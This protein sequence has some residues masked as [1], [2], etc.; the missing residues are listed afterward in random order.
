M[1]NV[2]LPPKVSSIVKLRELFL[3]TV[4]VAPAEVA[5]DSISVLIWSTDAAGKPYC[6][7]SA[8]VG[9]TSKLTPLAVIANLPGA[10]GYDPAEPAALSRYIPKNVGSLKE[11][12]P[13]PVVIIAFPPPDSLILDVTNVEP[14]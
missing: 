12:P 8:V 14:V 6:D 5:D 11:A 3:V 1:F 10:K 7:I 2:K 9:C 4:I 13:S